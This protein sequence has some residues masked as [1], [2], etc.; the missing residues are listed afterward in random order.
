M[1]VACNGSLSEA[2]V[3]RLHLLLITSCFLGL[4]GCGHATPGQI[5]KNAAGMVIAEKAEDDFV[6]SCVS[7]GNPHVSCESEFK[8]TQREG[9]DYYAEQKRAEDRKRA[10]KL[11][12]DFEEF[13]ND[14]V[15][16]ES[17]VEAEGN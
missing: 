1:R 9:K 11:S 15:T 8:K 10:K 17:T 6:E 7:Q 2:C 3:L 16:S 14:T 4:A 12:N 13:M 5:A